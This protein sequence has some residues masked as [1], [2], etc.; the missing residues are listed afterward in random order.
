MVT[1]TD[2]PIAAVATPPGKGGVGIVRLSGRNLTPLLARIHPGPVS[3]RRATFT[4]F[5][6]EAGG[7]IDQGLLLLPDLS[8]RL[9]LVLA[10]LKEI[11]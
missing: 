7:V 11:T 3:P 2:E 6:D 9:A 4:D 10:P 1:D 5:V 8:C